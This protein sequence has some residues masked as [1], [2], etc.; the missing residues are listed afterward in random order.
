MNLVL[1]AG[2]EDDKELYVMLNRKVK[3]ACE[4]LPA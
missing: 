2:M 3:Y 1:F 4:R